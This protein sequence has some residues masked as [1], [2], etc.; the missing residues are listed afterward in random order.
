[1]DTKKQR[2]IRENIKKK[3]LVFLFLILGISN[4]L[5]KEFNS[6]F[7]FT[8]DLPDG[9]EILNS[10]NLYNV[11]SSSHKDPFLKKQINRF[12]KI[13]EQQNIEILYNFSQSSVNNI[14][15]LVFDNEYKV[16][17][18]TVLKQC[19][20]IL[21]ISKKL[22]KRK[23]DLIECRMHDYPKFAKWSMYRENESSFFENELTQQII[24]QYKKKEYVITVA[25]LEKCKLM[26]KDLFDLVKSIEF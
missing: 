24:F 1:M 18:K 7:N 3:V 25:C 26:K 23:V 13:L 16:N 4:A 14:S 17:K 21:K 8:F 15:I 5:A 6:K 9:Y 10:L 22:G 11:Y 12:K 20:K 2:N 19:K